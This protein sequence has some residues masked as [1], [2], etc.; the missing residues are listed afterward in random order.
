M[1]KEDIGWDLFVVGQMHNVPDPNLLPQTLHKLALRRAVHSTRRVVHVLVA[2]ISPSVLKEI[3]DSGDDE[4]EDD[5]DHGDLL[6]K[7]VDGW[8]PVEEDDEEK[9]EVGKAMELLKQV[10]GYEAEQGVLGGAN[11][12]VQVSRVGMVRCLGSCWHVMVW[13]NFSVFSGRGAQVLL[14]LVLTLASLPPEDPLLIVGRGLP[15]RVDAV[16]PACLSAVC[17]SKHAQCLTN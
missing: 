8:H 4:D 13:N 12:I 11:P 15:Q 7:G 14:L 17:I 2:G 5:G 3:F 10:P 6:A 1:E 16:R 9:V